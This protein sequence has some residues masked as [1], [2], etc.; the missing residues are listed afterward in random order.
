MSL[1]LVSHRAVL[2]WL[3]VTI[4][5]FLLRAECCKNQLPRAPPTSLFSLVNQNS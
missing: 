2:V 3:R 4:Q 1:L 5:P